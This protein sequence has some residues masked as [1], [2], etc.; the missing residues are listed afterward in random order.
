MFRLQWRDS[1]TRELLQA[2][3]NADSD[4][5]DRIIAAMSEA[6][7]IL[8]TKADTAGES[9]EPGTR[10]LIAPPL[11]ITYRVNVRFQEV[12]IIRATVHDTKK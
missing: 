10:L 7:A 12:L 1:V 6:E 9:R 2:A 3:A 11:S 8:E 4:L 5:H